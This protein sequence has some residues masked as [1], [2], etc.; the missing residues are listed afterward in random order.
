MYRGR[1]LRAIAYRSI[2]DAREGVWY[3][4][5]LWF[6]VTLLVA[7]LSA[8]R[9]LP[10]RS[11]LVLTVLALIAVLSCVFAWHFVRNLRHPD[12]HDAWRRGRTLVL[13]E[14]D[15]Q[16]PASLTLTLEPRKPAYGGL[17]EL[18][19]QTRTEMSGLK[20]HRFPR[21]NRDKSEG[22][23]RFTRCLSRMRQLLGQARS[24]SDGWSARK[25]EGGESFFATRS[26]ST[27]D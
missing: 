18:K 19:S 1:R 7:G 20:C 13:T 14:R 24:E 3:D 11:F 22:F 23:K 21:R 6:V 27:F 4:V 12:Q 9:G 10:W 8:W 26:R 5:K 25:G 17:T 15:V 2:W 16:A